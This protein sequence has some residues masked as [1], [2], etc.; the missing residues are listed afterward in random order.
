[1][2]D[3][4]V[5]RTK[6]AYFSMEIALR[7]EMHTYAGGL[8][9]LAGD[10]VRSCSDLE[11]PVV[12]VTLLSRDGYLK[13]VIDSDGRQ[14]EEP[15][16]WEPAHWAQPLGAKVAISV[17][18][19]DVWVRPWLYVHHG[20]SGYDVPVILLDTDL[21]E[22]AAEDR[23]ITRALYD[24]D[25]THRLRQE[26]VLGI[27]GVRLLRSLGFETG[28]FH[29][30]EGHAALLALELLRSRARRNGGNGEARGYDAD[31]VRERCVFTTHTPIEAGHDRFPYDLV[32]QMLT[33]FLEPDVIMPFAGTDG[34]NMT[35]LALS[36][37]GY[38]NG[39]A[40]RHAETSRRLFPGFRIH[41]ITNGVHVETWTCPSVAGLFHQ[42]L[43][44]WLHEPELLV[45]ADRIDDASMWEAHRAAKAA[46]LAEVQARTGWALTP[47]TLT[48]GFA[49]RM[50][51]YKRPDLLFADLDRLRRLAGRHP[52][53]ILVAGKAHPYDDTGKRA[54]EAIHRHAEALAGSVPVVF[55]ANYDM[56]LA[57]RLTSGCDVWL[58]TPLPPLEAS[59][60]SG[61]KAALNGVLNLS[62]LDGWWMEACIEGTTGWAI[63]D[64]ELGTA[65]DDAEDLYRAL[66]DRVLPTYYGDRAR[67]IWMMKQSI[68]KIASCFNSQRM[69]RRYASEAYLR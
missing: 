33:G 65:D 11:L 29:M 41:A 50:T 67:W 19:R 43:P 51:D 27:G 6:I 5:Q 58:N 14:L 48:L 22:N 68:S 47:D 35:R 44:N 13:Q 57:Q 60:T 34:L 69:M 1:M 66:E 52:F 24:G 56:A 64:A 21:D 9:I 30:N 25:P 39:V 37:S 8:G 7:P 63:G 38:V 4:L 59:G 62:V 23:S 18:G 45:R 2:L 31:W 17:A 46:L 32:T 15:D 16:P 55:L 26:I 10:T 12:F 20:G 3:T 61:M 54:I 49:R 53:Q 36:L 42:C 28:T 40:K